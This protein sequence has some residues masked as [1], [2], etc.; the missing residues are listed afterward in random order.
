MTW[1]VFVC[2]NL[3]ASVVLFENEENQRIVRSKEFLEI[4]Q[5]L[6]VRLGF[7]VR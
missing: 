3:R 7:I 2:V 1:C 5:I 6:L 4:K